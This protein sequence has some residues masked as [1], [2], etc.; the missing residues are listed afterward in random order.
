MSEACIDHGPFFMNRPTVEDK[1]PLVGAGPYMGEG[2]EYTQLE[3]LAGI[4]WPASRKLV[5]IINQAVARY[6]MD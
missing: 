3:R 4:T 2:P 1:I 5:V 6:G